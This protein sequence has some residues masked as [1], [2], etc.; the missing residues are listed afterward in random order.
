MGA[1]FLLFTLVASDPEDATRSARLRMVREDI[2]QRGIRDL[3][4]LDAMRA[5]PRHEYVPKGWRDRAYS[6]RP[7]PIGHDQTISQPYVVAL[8][9][10]YL[11]LRAGQRVLEIGTGSGYQAAILDRLGATVFSI[12]IVPGLCRRAR[13]DLDRLGHADVKTRCGDGYRGWPEAAPFDRIIL[14]AAPPRIPT[15]LLEQLKP[16][17]R[18][19]APV[20]GRRQLLVVITKG[21]DGRLTREEKDMVAFVPM[22]GEAQ[23]KPR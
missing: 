13:R 11:D 12:E 6:D 2:A 18:L 9:T 17:G 16:G 10:D 22:T 8:M 5:E 23:E 19:V 14:T 3:R 7:L 21:V 4:I 20:G 1:L 15:P